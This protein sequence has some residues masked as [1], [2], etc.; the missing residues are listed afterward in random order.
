[1]VCMVR[2]YVETHQ[3]DVEDFPPPSST[4]PDRI[5]ELE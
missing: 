4:K 3:G 5:L 1:M 2:M